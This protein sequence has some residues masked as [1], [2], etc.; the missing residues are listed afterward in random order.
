VVVPASARRACLREKLAG[1]H[2]D[3]PT[4]LAAEVRLVGVARINCPPCK[5][6]VQG[7]LL[8]NRRLHAGDEAL[9]TQDAV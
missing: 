4:A 7:A 8:S 5:V 2:A 6:D 9:Q 1:R 3:E